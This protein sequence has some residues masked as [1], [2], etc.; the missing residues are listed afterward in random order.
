VKK[1]IPYIILIL[2]LAAVAL[3]IF[4]GSNEQPQRFDE[5]VTLRKR[6]KIPYG[7]Y[8]AFEELKHL[9]PKAIISTN[10]KEP[11]YWDSLN[12]FESGQALVVVSHRFFADEYEMK[13]ILKFAENGNDVFVSAL[14]L[15]EDVKNILR[16][17]IS[18]FDLSYVFS[19]PV[20]RNDT[21]AVSLADPPFPSGYDFSY[22]GRRFESHFSRIDTSTTSVLG[23]GFGGVIN[24]IHLKTG[25]GNVYFHLA[26]LTF[27]NYFLLQ[28][29]NLDYYEAVMSVISPDVRRIVWDEYYLDKRF[30]YEHNEEKKKSGW[31]STFMNYKSLKWALLTAI[32]TLLL[33]V[34]LEMRRKQ[35]YIP[36]LAPPRNDSLEFIRTI[37]RLYFEKGDHT[38]LARKM[39]AYFLEYVRNKYKLATSSLDEDF[40]RKLQFKTGYGDPEIRTIIS[41][42]RHVE[43]GG[44]VNDR[45]LADFH[46]HLESFY[47]NA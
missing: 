2:V 32:F 41:M 29:S 40:T 27:S 43:E 35:R 46:K 7:T 38:N 34:L 42:I 17:S 20:N 3:M 36:V 33:F 18:Y 26:P 22:P 39:S 47:Q 37:G 4:T 25:K 12:V 8:I 15:S 24:F 44:A 10:R 45:L 9:F 28:R 31:F 13:R 30:Y 14:V 19:D 5:R 6:D 21:L 11:V 1:A 16:C 23:S